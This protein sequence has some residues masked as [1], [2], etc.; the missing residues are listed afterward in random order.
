MVRQKKEKMIADQLETY[1]L[2]IEQERFVCAYEI[3]V[4]A[5]E[6]EGE[7]DEHLALAKE[8]HGPL[9]R[10]SMELANNK[11]TEFS[12]E[13]HEADALRRLVEKITT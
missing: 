6:E 3:L 2:R 12:D 11:A 7:T 1:R 13:V 4:N 5:I 8:L 9:F 10:K